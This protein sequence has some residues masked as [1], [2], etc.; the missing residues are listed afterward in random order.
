MKAELYLW[1]SYRNAESIF[2]EIKTFFGSLEFR[3]FKFLSRI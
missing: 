2:L 3:G 1:K